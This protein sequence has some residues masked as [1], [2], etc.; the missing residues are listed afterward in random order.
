MD[1]RLDRSA[2]A[3]IGAVL[4]A[5]ALVVTVM[6]PPVAAGGGGK[7]CDRGSDDADEGFSDVDV[8]FVGAHPDDDSLSTATLARL[9]DLCLRTAVIT[10]TRGEGGGN[11]VNNASGEEL[12]ELREAEERAAM[13]ILDVD[14]V[15]YLD[16]LD[17]FFTQS[18]EVTEEVWGH[19][20][21]LGTLVGL[22]E[23]LRPETIITM[24]P[25][26]NSGHGNHQ[27]IARLAT[28]AFNDMAA[29]DPTAYQPLK[30]YY[31]L[32]FGSFGLSGEPVQVPTDEPSIEDPTLTYGELEALA[33][34]EYL[35]QNFCPP[36]GRTPA[37]TPET[38]QLAATRVPLGS[39]DT[40]W[41]NASL[42]DGDVALGTLLG[43]DLDE[44]SWLPGSTHQVTVT[45]TNDTN[46]PSAARSARRA[47]D[48]IKAGPWRHVE[49]GVA[50]P[51][52]WTVAG[53]GDV[54]RVHPGATVSRTFDVTASD[55]AATALT[56][57][58]GTIDERD[59]SASTP[60]PLRVIPPVEA[61]LDVAEWVDVYREF[62][63][64]E[65]IQEF[66]GLSNPQFVAA[67]GSTTAVTATV[68]NN[69]DAAQSATI[70]L[71]LPDG[72]TADAA[73][74]TVDL[75]AGEQT[76]VSFDVTVAD[77][78][79]PGREQDFSSP[80]GDPI[81]LMLD[82]A[83]VSE[84]E[85]RPVPTVGVPRATPTI[86]GDLSDFPTSGA[87]DLN[88]RWEGEAAESATDYSGVG[89]VA[90][91]D[92]FVYVAADITDDD[93]LC[94]TAPD[95]VK[96]LF[97]TDNVEI[98]IDP[99]ASSG[100][101]TLTVFKIAVIPCTTEAFEAR[102]FREADE[103]E[104]VIEETAPAT[105]VASQPT[106]GGYT[107]EVAM[108]RDEMDDGGMPGLEPTFGLNVLPYDAAP[109]V[110]PDT[111]EE[112][113]IVPGDNYGQSRFG[114][115]VWG[116]VQANPYLWGLATLEP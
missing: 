19:D 34:C 22:L 104:G 77:S 70:G 91:D 103:D 108:P 63:R 55:G 65:G 36:G 27:F 15:H 84:G 24:N 46:R 1:T 47:G 113:P 48:R 9:D 52:G 28:E 18:S 50:V 62:T 57:V 59:F 94:T 3:R 42:P 23:R 49:L 92:D 112:L 79:E 72:Y 87:L 115:S 12:G 58:A 107:I 101:S 89:Y 96:K 17:F 39:P 66:A 74:Q 88:R 13:K 32:G 67:V 90:Y 2:W 78:V 109:K 8:V 111:G 83:V 44:F 116:A 97:R 40:L 26:A 95:D 98:G 5:V 33:L 106:A 4:L 53:D 31:G 51:D 82:G 105:Q 102:A 64:Q 20:D 29:S 6:A 61:A 30:L 69:T 43:T 38:F 54:G 100:I 16:E 93:V 71:Q 99:G 35:T 75:A 45:A 7:S 10:A 73:S 14:H 81:A 86:D 85:M 60:E 114:W 110:D 11:A 80:Q 68:T 37:T 76:T 56:S 41:A 25:S 21:A